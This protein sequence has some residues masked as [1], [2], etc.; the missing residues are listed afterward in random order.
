M[1]LFQDA[2]DV[3]IGRKEDGNGGNEDA[4]EECSGNELQL[5]HDFRQ[6]NAVVAEF[7]EV[8]HDVALR[9]HE[10]GERRRGRCPDQDEVFR[11]KGSYE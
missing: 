10:D 9:L 5:G 8:E 11:N 2:S 1:P 7:E 6:G 3:A 4:G